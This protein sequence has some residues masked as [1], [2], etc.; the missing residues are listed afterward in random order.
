MTLFS[1][2]LTFYDLSTLSLKTFEIVSS[3][4]F[5]FSSTRKHSIIKYDMLSSNLESPFGF[6]LKYTVA[7]V[8]HMVSLFTYTFKT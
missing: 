5:A 2:Y 1:D 3:K 8:C 6:D 4:V 7:T